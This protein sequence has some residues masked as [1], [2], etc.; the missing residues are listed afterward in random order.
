M[1][2]L[3]F[4]APTIIHPPVRQTD[5]GVPQPHSTLT[6]PPSVPS[7]SNKVPLLTQ[8]KHKELPNTTSRDH[9]RQGFQLSLVPFG[10]FLARKAAQI[11]GAERMT[12]PGA[13]TQGRCKHC[14]T[15]SVL[16]E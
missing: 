6:H 4:S 14:T 12:K 8:Q 1:K 7:V 11:V 9:L 15:S 5:R 13:P 10:V 16:Q 3:L 2:E